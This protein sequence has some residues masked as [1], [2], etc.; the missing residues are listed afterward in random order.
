MFT[1]IKNY[2]YLSV[3]VTSLPLF[4]SYLGVI[5]TLVCIPMLLFYVFPC[6]ILVFFSLASLSTPH[7][8]LNIRFLQGFDFEL[9]KNVFTENVSTLSRRNE[10]QIRV[11]LLPLGLMCAVS[12]FFKN[13]P[14]PASF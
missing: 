3:C 1:Y 12:W 9:K 14:T 7:P 4:L 5:G 2:M 8:L 13:G 6:P 10:I 11:F